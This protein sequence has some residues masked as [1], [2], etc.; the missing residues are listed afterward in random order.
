MRKIVLIAT[1]VVACA[2]WGTLPPYGHGPEP[3]VKVDSLSVDGFYLGQHRSAIPSRGVAW[4]AQSDALWIGETNK[5]RRI[6]LYF[7]KAGGVE[8]IF[9]SSLS[10]SKDSILVSVGDR[11]N[12]GLGKRLDTR[13]KSIS[14]R[15]TKITHYV[16]SNEK[17]S[18]SNHLFVQI[19][20][21]LFYRVV[22]SVVLSKLDNYP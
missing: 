20:N 14:F 17:N 13:G 7:D 4:T 12:P 16:L 11:P 6:F 2:M 5:G 8:T 1:V 15:D 22:T 3:E 21:D 9:G 18:T 19:E 10:T